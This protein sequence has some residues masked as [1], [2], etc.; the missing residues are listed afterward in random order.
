[1]DERKD[2]KFLGINILNGIEKFYKEWNERKYERTNKWMN[3]KKKK[4]RK[5]EEGKKTSIS[6]A[7]NS[8]S[9]Y[10]YFIT[11]CTH[12]H[13]RLLFEIVSSFVVCCWF[14][15][16]VLEMYAP[17]LVS[18]WICACMI[19]N[20][21]YKYMSFEKVCAGFNEFSSLRS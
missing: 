15:C 2:N 12:A 8:D 3:K 9:F 7:Y 10:E 14:W 1:M 19:Q 13:K 5:K 16:E 21:I 17:Y 20:I 4:Q 6:P 11:C 18:M